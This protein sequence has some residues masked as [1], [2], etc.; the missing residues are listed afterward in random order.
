MKALLG[1]SRCLWAAPTVFGA[2][3]PILTGILLFLPGCGEGPPSMRSTM[4]VPAPFLAPAAT[5]K[6]EAWVEETLAGL[7]LE[8]KVGQLVCS[9]ISGEYRAEDDPFLQAWVRLARDH[10][11]GMFVLYGGTPRDVAHL[12]N[13]LQ[14]E[15]KIPILFSADFEGGPG[16]QVTRASEFPANMAFSATGSEELMYRAASAAAVE[17]RAMGIHLTYTPVVD[18]ATQPEN[19]A[20]SVRSFGGDLDL[21]DRMVEAYVRGFH[22]NGMLTTAKHYPGR[23]DIE[24]MPGNAPWT[25]INKPAEAVQEG[26]FRAFQF[27]IDAGVDF[28]MS[29]HIAVPSVT[30]GSELPASVEE[31]LVSG[32]LRDRL[33]FEGILTSDDLW[34]E[35]VVERFGAEEVAVRAFEAGH[36]IILKPKD[37]VAAIEALVEAVRSGRIPE[38][39]V[40]RAVRRLLTLKARL[41]LHEHRY[42]D[43]TRVGEKVGTPAHLA[44]VQEVADRSL[45]LLKNEGVLPVSVDALGRVVNLNVQKAQT[46]PSPAALDA[47]L[48]GAIPGTRSFTLRPG[49]GPSVYEAAWAEVTEADLVILSLFVPRDRNGDATPVRPADL[50]FLQQ[51]IEAKQGRVVAVAYGNPHLIREIPEVPAFLVG[52][53]ERGWYGNQH[54]YFDSFV[55]ALTGELEPPGRLPVLVSEEYPIGSGMEY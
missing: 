28:V 11:L 8:R 35:H 29:E 4:E 7:T 42:V 38:E 47:V 34:Y 54:V 52:Y 51:V 14:K 46:D 17:G 19:P 43:E 2:L 32:W 18:I 39:R 5:P 20:Q 3:A 26:D 30:E 24:I 55:R 27:A 13:R 50:S 22:E 36:D 16:Q 48:A 44:L 49:T 6:M 33:G 21:L 23:G 9:D 25:W 45:T 41:G 10:G 1:G 15:T 37:P 53:G 40:N 31:K 12:L